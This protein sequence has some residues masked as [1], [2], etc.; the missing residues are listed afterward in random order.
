MKEIIEVCQNNDLIREVA[1]AGFTCDEL[2]APAPRRR[3]RHICISAVGQM[4][5]PVSTEF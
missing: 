3:Q 1:L 4:G 2:C 5:S